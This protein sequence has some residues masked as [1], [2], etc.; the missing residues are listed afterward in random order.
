MKEVAENMMHNIYQ[1][2]IQFYFVEC[3]PYLK[4]KIIVTK[5]SKMLGIKNFI[6]TM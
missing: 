4:I 5:L 1:L 3:G 2:S 6:G